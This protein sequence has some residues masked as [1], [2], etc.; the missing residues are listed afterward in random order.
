MVPLASLLPSQHTPTHTQTADSPGKYNLGRC[1]LH[2]HVLLGQCLVQCTSILRSCHLR[3]LSVVTSVGRSQAPCAW[4]FW[5]GKPLF[6]SVLVRT[7]TTQDL[8]SASSL[9]SLSVIEAPTFSSKLVSHRHRLR[10]PT[11][12]AHA[13]MKDPCRILIVMFSRGQS[14]AFPSCK[15]DGLHPTSRG[16][17][18]M[19]RL[20][21]EE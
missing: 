20:L 10:Y 12:H 15:V 3:R 7:Q 19:L 14:T 17:W 11:D 2:L 1:L 6:P 18:K 16:C 13:Q 5:R 21:L 8:L 9:K 4:D